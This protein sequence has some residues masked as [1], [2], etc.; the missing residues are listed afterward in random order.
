MRKKRGK[1]LKGK[2]RLK[3]PNFPMRKNHN[4]III[5]KRKKSKYFLHLESILAP[6]NFTD[7]I[8]FLE[9]NGISGDAALLILAW[10]CYGGIEK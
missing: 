10:A 3:S 8:N 6:C 5:P 4:S 7:C 9:Q 2:T 1:F